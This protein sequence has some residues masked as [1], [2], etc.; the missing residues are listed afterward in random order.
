MKIG[1][2]GKQ[3][4]F[5][6]EML[7]RMKLEHSRDEFLTW[8]PGDKAPS[9]GLEVLLAVGNVGAKELE[10]QTKLGLLQMVSAGYDGVDVDAATK[11]GIW[12]ASACCFDNYMA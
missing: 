3:D 2:L 5:A 12:V 6:L 8:L 1:Y 9:M 4:S 11:A 10:G 7:R